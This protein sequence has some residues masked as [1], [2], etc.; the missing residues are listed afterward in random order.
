MQNF[1]QFN[2]VMTARND[3]AGKKAYD[4]IVGLNSAFKSRLFYQNLDITSDDSVKAFHKWLSTTFTRFDVLVNNAAVA[5]KG[6]E[7]N[8]QVVDFTLTP[9]FYGTINL[10]ETLLPLINDN[11]SIV[12]VSSQMGYYRGI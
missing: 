1:S 4:E 5:T 8:A 3:V 10:T 12:N 2:V 9:N 7:F 11:G 6:S